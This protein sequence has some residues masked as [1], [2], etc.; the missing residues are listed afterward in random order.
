MYQQVPTRGKGNT[1]SRQHFWRFRKESTPKFQTE[2]KA[3]GLDIRKRIWK[4]LISNISWV[5]A[6]APQRVPHLFTGRERQRPPDWTPSF[7]LDVQPLG[8]VVKANSPA[9]MASHLRLLRHWNFPSSKLHRW[10]GWETH[11]FNPCGAFFCNSPSFYR[12]L[13]IPGMSSPWPSSY[14]SVL[15]SFIY[16]GI[17]TGLKFWK[18]SLHEE[19]FNKKKDTDGT[20]VEISQYCAKWDDQIMR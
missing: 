12:T 4:S 15:N 6:A 9:T 3:T 13:K 7:D 14:L 17:L 10:G 11:T 20:W 5:L 1:G 8:H 19:M 16:V 18:K 2:R